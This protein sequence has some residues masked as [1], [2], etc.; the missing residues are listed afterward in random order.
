[1]LKLWNL[2]QCVFG[3]FP[4][5]LSDD[6]GFIVAEVFVISFLFS[7]A[8]LYMCYL[9]MND[10]CAFYKAPG[11]EPQLI[12][13]Y[14]VLATSAILIAHRVIMFRRTKQLMDAIFRRIPYP[15]RFF[16]ITTHL[17]FFE[18]L[19]IVSRLTCLWISRPG[20]RRFSSV[21]VVLCSYILL[22][23]PLLIESQFILV[24]FCLQSGIAELNEMLIRGAA[25]SDAL[26]LRKIRKRLYKLVDYF[27]WALKVFRVDLFLSVGL[28]IICI[29]LSMN[30]FT[31][32]IFKAEDRNV[33]VLNYL[34]KIMYFIIF[35]VVEVTRVVWLV[36]NSLEMSKSVSD[37]VIVTCTIDC[38]LSTSS[39][40][41]N[42]RLSRLS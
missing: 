40:V 41:L 37:E 10:V 16:T 19:S 31:L 15:T 28:V 30:D 3:T 4:Y 35:D 12:G 9:T 34:M 11:S 5:L 13:C 20:F 22:L 36:Y 39:I 6:E 42:Y 26:E 7:F 29:L 1:M 17:T 32:T 2:C 25:A 23:A 14:G 24:C 33:A 18:A 21:L 27:E 8:E 38:L